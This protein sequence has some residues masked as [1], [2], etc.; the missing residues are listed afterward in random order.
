M[1]R[2]KR[3]EPWRPFLPAVLQSE[4]ATYFDRGPAESRYMLFHYRSRTQALPAV[5]HFDHTSRL[6]QVGPETGCCTTCSLR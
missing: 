2:L 1:N 4:S 3:R 6:Q 5:T